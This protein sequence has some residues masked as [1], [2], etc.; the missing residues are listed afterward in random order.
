MLK[1]RLPASDFY[2]E[3]NNE[4]VTFKEVTLRFEH[5]LTSIAK[6][7]AKWHK[8]FLT[9]EDKTNEE[10][11]DYVRCMC[12]DEV[13]E[14]TI[15]RLNRNDLDRLNKYIEDPMT[16]TWFN[17][18][19]RGRPSREIVTSELIYYWMIQCEIPFECQNWHLNRLLTLIRVCDVKNA[20]P[21]KMSKSDLMR[22]NTMLNDARRKKL[23]TRG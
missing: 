17:D 1:I 7:E 9:K 13:D 22:R 14:I 4:F 10:M 3:V 6:W 16:A 2:D 8:A 18:S 20:P 11:E 12:L 21:K 19:H 5:S 23:N 15:R